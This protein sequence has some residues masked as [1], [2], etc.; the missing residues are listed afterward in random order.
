LKFTFSNFYL[1]PTQFIFVFVPPHF[2]DQFSGSAAESVTIA[3]N[4]I[5]I[6]TIAIALTGIA[7]I[8]IAAV[9]AALYVAE[10]AAGAT[11]VVKFL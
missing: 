5:E 9:G 11:S 4:T 2:I 10:A 8:V 3:I 6:A 1:P 7:T